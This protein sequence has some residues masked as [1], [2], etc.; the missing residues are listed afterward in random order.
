MTH[1]TFLALCSLCVGAGE[2][3]SYSAA[4]QTTVTTGKPMMVMVSTD[5]CVPCQ[6]MKK[7][8]IPQVRQ[9]G[10]LAKV[11]FAIVNPD[12]D[13]DLAER[14]IGG[15]PVPQ[16]IMFR[17]TANGWRR[18]KLIGGQT[19]EAVEDFINDGI[20]KEA[21]PATARKPTPAKAAAGQPGDTASQQVKV[22]PSSQE[23][24]KDN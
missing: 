7:T 22:L 4:H 23:T 15:G 1:L 9:R 19:V 3:D 21:S 11:A 17:K 5:W 6:M 12:R 18:R 20:A 2:T 13:R 14:L 10:L 24:V 16:L 8:I